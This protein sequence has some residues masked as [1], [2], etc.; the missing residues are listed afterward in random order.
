MKSL[1]RTTVALGL[2]VLIA[3][4]SLGLVTYETIHGDPTPATVQTLLGVVLGFL[5]NNLASA[6]GA[7][8]ALSTPP[9][10]P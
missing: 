10:T 4:V 5:G 1:N 9:P 3:V 7:E 2:L 6:Q 8:Q